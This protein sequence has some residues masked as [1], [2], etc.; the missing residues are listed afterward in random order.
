VDVNKLTKS[1][2]ENISGGNEEEFLNTCKKCGKVWDIRNY[3][4]GESAIPNWVTGPWCPECRKKDAE[5]FF[6]KSGDK[7]NTAE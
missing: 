3:G 2:L 6:K 4:Y 7:N 1:D 5:E